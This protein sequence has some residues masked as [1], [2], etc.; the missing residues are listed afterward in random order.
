MAVVFSVE[1]VFALAWG[2]LFAIV[3]AA[4]GIGMCKRALPRDGA[5][6]TFLLLV[7]A[8][9][10]ARGV[11]I[12]VPDSIAPTLSP[13]EH[14]DT[15]WWGNVGMYLAYWLGHAMQLLV[16]FYLLRVTDIALGVAAAAGF[17]NG[18][19]I[20]GL[21]RE[22]MYEEQ[23]HS[24]RCSPGGRCT[25]SAILLGIALNTLADLGIA[26]TVL[27]LPSEQPVFRTPRFLEWGV[28]FT[29][30]VGLCVAFPVMWL[31]LSDRLADVSRASTR[32][33][34]L[35]EGWGMQVAEWRA[36]RSGCCCCCAL[37]CSCACCSYSQ[38]CNGSKK[39]ASAGF[40]GGVDWASGAIS[41]AATYGGA[42]GVAAAEAASQP[43]LGPHGAGDDAALA[44]TTAPQ[45]NFMVSVRRKLWRLFAVGVATVAGLALRALT[46]FLFSLYYFWLGSPGQLWPMWLSVFG[47]FLPSELL[48]AVTVI[49]VFWR[50]PPSPRQLP[51]QRGPRR[52]CRCSRLRPSAAVGGPTTGASRSGKGPKGPASRMLSEAVYID[53]AG[54]VRSSSGTLLRFDPT[55][56]DAAV[57]VAARRDEA[58]VSAAFNGDDHSDVAS[59][60]DAYL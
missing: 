34:V 52:C 56:H 1:D 22:A 50:P 32:C 7:I 10:V 8:A 44:G 15:S 59:A 54:A 12:S 49:A 17:G 47:R 28:M 38:C 40:S 14:G 27:V 36:N 16:S 33:G 18:A 48:I 35:R 30:C 55:L 3:A 45:A 13:G 42:P 25:R 53:A 31:A 24:K 51:Q 20:D 60:S 26:V 21:S 37:F 39:G 2:V 6:G 57:A 19:N 29:A 4:L 46:I 41:H 58:I 5:F 43:F 11:A 9:L 23:P